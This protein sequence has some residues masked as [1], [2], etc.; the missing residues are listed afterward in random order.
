MK[1][2]MALVTFVFMLLCVWS[3]FA[4]PATVLADSTSISTKSIKSGSYPTEAS[5]FSVN[6]MEAMLPIMTNSSSKQVD[7]A[8]Y[9]T[10][11]WAGSEYSGWLDSA[12][13]IN[14]SIDVPD[15]LP[16][17]GDK[18][19]VLLSVFDDAQS[20]D[21]IGLFAYQGN[22]WLIWSY[23]T[24]P[25]IDG[26]LHSS[27]PV[28]ACNGTA[29]SFNI[30]AQNGVVYFTA[31]QG[32]TVS[33][34]GQQ[35][36]GGNYLI[37]ATRF[38][39]YGSSWVD[40][41]DY[42]EVKQTQVDGGAP[43]FNFNFYNQS[44]VATDGTSFA[45][46]WEKYIVG[47]DNFN[48]PDFV[49]VA[50]N[51]DSVLVM[52]MGVDL[53]VSSVDPL[54]PRYSPFQVYHHG[55]RYVG[56]NYTITYIVTVVRSDDDASVASL[57]VEVG[58]N[59]TNVN[60]ATDSRNLATAEIYLA[61]GSN[62]TSYL[63][64]NETNTLN[65][66]NY[67]I[68]GYANSLSNETWE[69]NPS[70]NQLTGDTVQAETLP[71]DINGVGII[72]ILDAIAL[73]RVW[74]LTNSSSNWN[75][76]ADLKPDGV[77]NTLDAIVL[78]NHFGA[79]LQGGNGTFGSDGLVGGGAQPLT[80]GAPSL[81]V[82][83]TQ[84]TAFKGDSFTV[85]IDVQSVTDLY[86]WEF[87]LY[88]NNT[89][90]NCTNAVI[91]TPTEWQNNS[92]NYGS[93]LEENYN[94]TTALYWVGQSATSP[95]SSFNGSMTIATLTFQALQ[96]GTSSLTLADTVLGDSTAQPI[97]CTVS[98]GSVTVYSGRYM[99]S[100][101]QTINGLGA[102]V[103]NV[104]ESTTSNSV[105]QGGIGSGWSWGIRAFVRHSDG[106]EQ[107]ISLNGQT[108]TPEAVVYNGNGLLSVTVSV[109]QTSLQPTD[110][111]VIR[112][113]AAVG[114]S[115][116]TLKVT[117]TT[118][119][120]QAT[121]LQAATWTVYYYVTGVYNRHLGITGSTFYW[122]TTTYESRIQNLLYS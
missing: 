86:G 34:S 18:Y 85:N 65:P 62:Y 52:N 118:E 70:D 122:G 92:Q 95:A 31:C 39:A 108:G 79:S 51:G 105:Y 13:S 103:L 110:S 47:Y 37:I 114:N 75:P 30:T 21:Q 42:E 115:G 41:T 6:K 120:L 80:V 3:L 38:T 1:R 59:R 98:S 57:C 107:E 109:S 11:W 73:G 113:Y 117:F 26:Y 106:S 68:T 93:G 69:M 99:R 72:N 84:L 87:Q 12:T 88:W 36:T 55:M 35:A 50:I 4:L 16:S 116:W 27:N 90:L 20:Y 76:D 8:G 48:V 97:N 96:P 78:G 14:G 91:Q 94:A 17:S 60:N 9:T 63:I 25:P 46:T 100:D 89:V 67:S 104:P 45:P 53:T 44:W 2:K 22:W 43:N 71:C 61:Y 28:P 7:P 23:S 33:M 40:Y 64:W 29:Y 77:I 66:G 15:S 82:D 54:P 112:V 10:Q 102:Y 119:Q 121:T 58:L 32:S 56:Q 111:L 81:L 74:G 49:S 24:G 101:T 19:A 83:P 5:D